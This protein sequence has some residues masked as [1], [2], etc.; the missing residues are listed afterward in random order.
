[1]T[2]V[3]SL[4]KLGEKIILRHL[5]WFTGKVDHHTR[6]SS[7]PTQADFSAVVASRGRRMKWEVGI[8]GTLG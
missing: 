2:Q 3:D 4:A 1:M 8:E 6:L 5:S 7:T